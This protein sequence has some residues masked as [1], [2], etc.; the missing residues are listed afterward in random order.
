MSHIELSFQGLESVSHLL[1]SII[2]MLCRNL[3]PIASRMKFQL[4]SS[5]HIVAFR[6]IR[7]LEDM[8]KYGL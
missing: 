8:L 2:K 6:V 5:D 4:Q 7:G 3:E 1:I